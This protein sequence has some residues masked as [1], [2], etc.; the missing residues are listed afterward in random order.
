MRKK[1]FTDPWDIK[2]YF[3]PAAG[4]C[5]YEVGKDFYKNVSR[6]HVSEVVIE[7][8]NKFYFDNFRL[9]LLQLIEVGG[10]ERNIVNRYNLCTI[11][12]D[13]YHSY[14]RDKSK[15]KRQATVVVL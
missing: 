6:R 3:G 1:F 11:C 4:S 13:L 15:S 12:N 10:L 5:C 8:N 14:R 2:V 9:N 7:K